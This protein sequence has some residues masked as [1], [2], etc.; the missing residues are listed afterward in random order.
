MMR[1]P[2][3]STRTTTLLPYT[4]LFRSLLR[5]LNLSLAHQKNTRAP[6]DTPRPGS[7]AKPY[8]TPDLEQA[9]RSEEHTSEL[10]S[11]MG[12]SY[13]VFCMNKN[14]CDTTNN[15]TIVPQPID[16]ILNRLQ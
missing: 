4:T 7:G 3:R 2:P 14:K 9:V 13:A 5:A 10:Q 15:K 8:S 12:I 11:L 6:N 16:N 1:R